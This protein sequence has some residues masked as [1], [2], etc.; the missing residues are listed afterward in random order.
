MAKSKNHPGSIDERSGSYR[1]R[2]CVA[3]ERHTYTF[4]DA[5]RAEV[6]EFAEKKEEKLRERAKRKALGL[7]VG[8]TVS[9]LLDRY[10]R[11]EL[12]TLSEGSQRTYPK[13][14]KPIRHFFTKVKDDPDVEDVRAVHVKEFMTWRRVHGPGG[15]KRKEPLS[16]LTV[17]KDRR[18]L[19]RVFELADQWEIRDGNPVSR[20]DPPKTET[21]DPVL[22]TEAELERLVE[23]CEDRPMLRTYT[24]LLAETGL[25]SRS[26]ALWLRWEDVD[27]EEGFLWVDSGRHGRRTKSGKGRYVPLTPLLWRTLQ[28]HASAF[29]ERTYGKPAKRSPWVFHHPRTR[30]RSKAGERIS[31]MRGR[32]NKAVERAKLPEGFRRHDLRHRRATTWLAAGADVVKVK[33][34]L[35]HSALATTMRYTHLAKEHLRSLV[36]EPDVSKAVSRNRRPVVENRSGS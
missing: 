19:H 31:Y 1:L 14:L 10:K 28:E 27:L 26:E 30:R 16:N 29:K 5:T 11:E 23:A 35:G 7:P 25:R 18:V 6:E 13:S 32:F 9:E 8:V 36:D 2:L 24:I 21:R 34:A 22:L 15:K 12:P 4:K 20:V 17:A 3:G 33:E